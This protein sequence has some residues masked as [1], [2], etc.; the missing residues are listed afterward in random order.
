MI[1]LSA[2]AE[3]YVTLPP[4]RARAA[5]ESGLV[6]ARLH[7]P[8]DGWHLV[9]G[10]KVGYVGG[11]D[12]EIRVRPHLAIPKLMFLLGY[13]ADPR[14]W[15]DDA[16]LYGTEDDAFVAI[17]SG[18]AHHATVALDQGPLRGYV[19]I[20]E[21]TPSFRGRLR[22]ADQAARMRGLP[23]PLELTYDDFTIDVPENRLLYAAADRLLRF[24][25][26]P[27]A[28][29]TRLLRVRAALDG[30]SSPARIVSPPPTRLNE[31][32]TAALALA[33]LVL[34]SASVTTERGTT[35]S[36]AFVFDMNVV[37][38]GFLSAA[39][40]EELRRHGGTVRTQDMSR[41][42]D[43][44]RGLAL[45]P[46]ISWWIGGR[47]R[48]VVDAK[49]KPLAMAGFPNADAYQMLAYCTG[50]RLA[51][52]T[53]VYAHDPS[54]RPRDHRVVD[55]RT[56]IRVRTVDVAAEPSALLAQVGELAADLAAR[57]E[58]ATSG[59]SPVSGIGDPRQVAAI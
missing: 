50:Y 16:A 54:E 3:A 42:L 45:K 5:Q 14:G 51:E 58:A 25:R 2:W 18:F 49:Y 7:D 21:R 26:V 6:V 37:F 30:V 44:E 39:L 47:C 33:S 23:L 19:S 52:G 12:W 13:A 17:A 55:D 40:T 28:A 35:P 41:H 29:R 48:A 38:E 57:S 11:A 24:P 1:S 20:D 10:S 4:A 59:A 53:L 8:P 56:T 9:T 32:Y 43:R 46:D 27:G 15:R 22:F 36:I 34:R 31:R